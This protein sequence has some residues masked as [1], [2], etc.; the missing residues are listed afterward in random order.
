[1][2]QQ[3]TTTTTIPQSLLPISPL[4]QSWKKHVEEQDIHQHVQLSTDP[5]MDEPGVAAAADVVAVGNVEVVLGEVVGNNAAFDGD[6]VVEREHYHAA[7]AEA[8]VAKPVAAAG[9]EVAVAVASVHH[10]HLIHLQTQR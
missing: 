8:E 5:I 9:N 4:L 2:D 6:D 10:T 1:M 7:E 3:K